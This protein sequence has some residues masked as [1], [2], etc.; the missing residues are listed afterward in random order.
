MHQEAREDYKRKG[1]WKA[2]FKNKK[3]YDLFCGV[4]IHK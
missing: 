3:I 4:G 1:S 2:S